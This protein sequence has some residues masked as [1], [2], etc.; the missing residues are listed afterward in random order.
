MDI[1]TWSPTAIVAFALA[2]FGVQQASAQT[3]ASWSGAPWRAGVSLYVY[4]PSI[5]GNLAFP[6]RGGS[7]SVIVDTGDVFDSLNGAF[8]GNLEVHNGQWG[9]FTDFLYVNVSGD[10]S[11]T[12][13]FSIGGFDVPGGVTGDFDLRVKGSAWTIV[14][15]YRAY[16]SPEL[17]LDFLAGARLLNVKPRLDWSLQGN[18]SSLPPISR[19]GNIEIEANNWDGIVGVKGRYELGGARGWYLPFYGD[20]GGGESKL[21]YQVAAGVGYAFGW[22]DIAL[23][24]RYIGYEMKSGQPV[25]DLKLSGPMIGATFRW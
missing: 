24:Y 21:T 17:T 5:D 22:G 6:T 10:R 23:L 11:G 15:E 19:G 7:G 4:L 16:S 13:N 1:R 18:V 2:I 25:E 14:G 8:M 12:R 20:I 3:N 9:V